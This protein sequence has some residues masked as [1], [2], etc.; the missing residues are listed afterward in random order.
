M[1]GY[2]EPVHSDSAVKR[3]N[4]K[5]MRYSIYVQTPAFITNRFYGSLEVRY[6]RT[7]LMKQFEC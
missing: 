3:T 7:S 5:S 6:K 1:P 4:F 2:K